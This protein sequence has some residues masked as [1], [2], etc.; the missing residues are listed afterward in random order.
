M[1]NYYTPPQWGG[2]LVEGIQPAVPKG[3]IDPAVGE[4]SLLR[5]SVDRFPGASLF[6]IDIDP[7][8]V[9][10]A[11]A[12]LPEAV[13]VEA[14]ALDSS[15]LEGTSIWDRR[16]EIDTVV[17]NPP[18]AGDRRS[19]R[20]EALGEKVVCGLAAAHL[21]S[22]MELF[23]P[24]IVAAIMPRSFFHSDRDRD[25]LQLI[26]TTYDLARAHDLRRTAFTK[27]NASSEMVYFRGR[28]GGARL[29]SVSNGKGLAAGMRPLGIRACLVRGGVPVHVAVG[30]RSK[31]GLPFVHTKG[32]SDSSGFRF[33]VSPGRRGVISGVAILVPRVGVPKLSHLDVRRISTPV[34]L[35]DCVI[36]LCFETPQQAARVAVIIRQNFELALS[37][38]DG[39]GAPYTTVSKLR[40]QLRRFGIDCRIASSWTPA[41]N[42]VV[43]GRGATVAIT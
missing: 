17:I 8:A 19:Y 20:V 3:I 18:F 22:S 28:S 33:R 5:C 15:S 11:R 1:T 25:A 38:W 4:G 35:S 2:I 7:K 23:A 26:R 21:L 36:A 40:E 24:S 12:E 34:Q 42:A 27:G 10:N 43:H 13:V 32:L 14:N 41:G 9:A 6:G 31:E 39:T 16:R 37:C 30:S 29:E